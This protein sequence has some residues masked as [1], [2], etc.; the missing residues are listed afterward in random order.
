MT[1]IRLVLML[2][3]F[4]VAH[5]AVPCQGL[6]RHGGGVAGVGYISH[7]EFVGWKSALWCSFD[8]SA[9]CF[10]PFSTIFSMTL[11]RWLM[12]LIVQWFWQCCRLPFFGSVITKDW[13]H[14]LVSCLPDLAADCHESSVYILSTFLDQFCW[15]VVNSSWLPFLQW[16]YYSL[17]FF[18]KDGMVIL[19]ICLGIV[20]CW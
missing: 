1:Q 18:V 15:D 2:H 7:R 19:C 6:W 10:N 13:V 8:F 5:K 14:R 3:F 4:M 11:L 9:C 12:R 20:Q 16:L 17:H